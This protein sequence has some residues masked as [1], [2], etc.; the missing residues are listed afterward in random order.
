[1]MVDAW[2][3][4]IVRVLQPFAQVDCLSAGLCIKSI[5]AEQLTNIGRLV[6]SDW[7]LRV[8]VI[9]R[10]VSNHAD[11]ELSDH[12]TRVNTIELNR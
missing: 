1:M 12:A 4:G 2:H 3:I 10:A 6:T 9:K 7:Y 11:L 8:Q 5:W